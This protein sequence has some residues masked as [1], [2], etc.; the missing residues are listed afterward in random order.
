MVAIEKEK[1]HR[2]VERTVENETDFNLH[3]KEMISV[4]KNEKI[5]ENIY[6]KNIKLSNHAFERFQERINKGFD[7]MRAT[8]YVKNDLKNAVRVGVIL[9]FE[10]RINVLYA[11]NNI[12][13]Y[14]SPDLKTVVTIVLYE[15]VNEEIVCYLAEKHNVNSSDLTVE[16]IQNLHKKEVLELEGLE[17][18]QCEILMKLEEEVTRTKSLCRD[19][20]LQANSRRKEK[21][22]KS[23]ISSNNYKLKIEGRK[24]FKISIKKR[25]VLR[26]MVALIK[27]E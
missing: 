16:E 6:V 9:S 10:G 1:K 27:G 13:Y 17:K 2:Y 8:R 18:E 20:I 5:K 26:S 25:V 19:L 23:L 22:Y 4:L 12:G 15:N 3:I 21:G 11:Y 7:L 24:L 14:L